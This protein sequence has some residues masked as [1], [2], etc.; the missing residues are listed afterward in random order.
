M[1]ARNRPWS[2]S[3]DSTPS[4]FLWR[5]PF[6]DLVIEIDHVEGFEPPDA[7]VDHLKRTLESVADKASVRIAPYEVLPRS[8]IEA[9][10]PPHEW[11]PEALVELG[12]RT[13]T[14]ADEGGYTRGKTAVIHVLFL[15]GHL[16]GAAGIEIDGTAY[17]F[18]PSGYATV[19]QE[20]GPTG[21]M[22]LTSTLLHEVGHAI[23]LVNHGIPMVA[24]HESEEHPLHSR[25]PRSVMWH[26]ID[27]LDA[28]RAMIGQ[29]DPPP[30][31][32]DADD[33]ADL[34]AFREEGRSWAAR[35]G[36][37]F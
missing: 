28:I 11:T 10:I 19:W 2:K 12:K 3:V 18:E 17:V 33:L 27:D 8:T 24:D 7:A 9:G 23:G 32:F 13:L 31:E 14:Y 21:Q 15:D 6:P 30:A 16:P 26:A 20:A 4:L 1:A 29:G 36:Y 35:N 37:A 22:F 34:A 5:H 25:N